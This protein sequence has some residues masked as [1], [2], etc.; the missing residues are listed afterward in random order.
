MGKQN[1]LHGK[2]QPRQ[3]E[4]ISVALIFYQVYKDSA[5]IQ[6]PQSQNN[7]V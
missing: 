3:F 4:H 5:W 6:N 7:L 1:I 2:L